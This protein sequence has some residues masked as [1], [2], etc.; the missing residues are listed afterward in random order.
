[1]GP[2]FCNVQVPRQVHRTRPPIGGR[3]PPASSN[4]S[5]SRILLCVFVDVQVQESEDS[6]VKSYNTPKS[7]RDLEKWLKIGCRA[8]R[9]L[10]ENLSNNG[11][12]TEKS[13]CGPQLA[14][15]EYE[16]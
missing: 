9:Y 10:F 11:M 4:R 5:A 2:N 6:A 16:I 13:Y 1:M 14:D 8:T 7:D 3:Q 12:M 15:E